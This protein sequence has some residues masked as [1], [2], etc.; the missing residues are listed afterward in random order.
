MNSLL[1]FVSCCALSRLAFAASV[2]SNEPECKGP[3]VQTGWADEMFEGTHFGSSTT[4]S[5]TIYNV[6]AEQC[7][8]QCIAREGCQAFYHGTGLP[9]GSAED[10]TDLICVLFALPLM[11]PTAPGDLA[12][13]INLEPHA[14]GSVYGVKGNDNKIQIVSNS[15][16]WYTST[17]VAESLIDLGNNPPQSLEECSRKCQENDECHSFGF[18]RDY[19]SGVSSTRPL[20]EMFTKDAGAPIRPNTPQLLRLFTK[21]VNGTLTGFGGVSGNVYRP[22]GYKH[23]NPECQPRKIDQLISSLNTCFGKKRELNHLTNYYTE[24]EVARKANLIRS[25]IAP[26]PTLCKKDEDGKLVTDQLLGNVDIE[27][28]EVGSELSC[29]IDEGLVPDSE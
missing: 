20:C 29:I 11:A 7:R 14:A 15:V 1:F 17:R 21:D 25:C 27:Q 10:L 24:C 16:T 26:V 22:D 28:T 18:I 9:C 6:T 5:R 13:F 23:S 2:P 4:L 19:R 8:N 3:L 12:P